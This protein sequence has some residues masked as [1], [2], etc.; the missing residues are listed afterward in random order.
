MRVLQISSD[1]S[2]RGVLYHGTP[3][4]KRQEAY[5]RQFGNLDIVGFSLKN[6]GAGTIEAGALRIYP[7]GSSSRILYGWDAFRI[8][9]KL[10]KP[11]I[12]SVQDPFETGLIG[13][14][15][16]RR[17]GAPL[18]AQVHTDF[19]SPEYAKLSLVNRFRIFI[20]G[21]VLRRASR[22]RVVSERIRL[23]IE[24]RYTLRTPITVLPIFVDIE[25][26]R[27][28]LPDEMLATRFQQFSARV[29][30][31]SR[32][33]P[34][35]D[36][37]AA[38]RVFGE[39]APESACLIV[40]GN[41]SMRES[42]EKLS[43]SL[44]IRGRIFFE[45]AEDVASYYKLADV[46]LLTS[47]YEGY[48]LAIVEA[49][50]AGKPVISTDVGAARELGAIVASSFEELGERM[51]DWFKGGLRKALLHAYPYKNFEEYVRAYCDDVAACTHTQ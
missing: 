34:E 29:L 10:P 42:L 9:R 41:G 46:V 16:A 11:D 27:W 38:V 35:K 33:E 19:L 49:L 20:A 45:D 22:V 6:D 44:H 7:T 12:V 4:F 23:G 30:I 18:H 5:A 32:L 8:A 17:F 13:W 2:K 51:V 24:T 48:G 47:K 39:Y 26:F 3:A 36:V 21:F 25:H 40:I 28:R 14:W 15:I 31:V 43:E 37:G 1:R 50:A